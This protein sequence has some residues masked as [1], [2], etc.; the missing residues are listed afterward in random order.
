MNRI[1]GLGIVC[2]RMHDHVFGTLVEHKYVLD[3]KVN[4]TSLGALSDTRYLI[5]GDTM[6]LNISKGSSVLTAV[7]RV[8]ELHVL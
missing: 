2:T 4:L 7:R 1:V 5:F 6:I 8:G 3:L